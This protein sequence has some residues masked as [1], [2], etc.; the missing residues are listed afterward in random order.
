[1]KY[2]LWFAFLGVVWWIWS[3]RKASED[4]KPLSS[5]PVPAEEKM[6]TCVHCGVHLPESE[7]LNDGG[8][9]YCCEAHRAASSSSGR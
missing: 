6:V 9:I 2:L 4:S 8:R 1:M 3:K 5:R 7:G